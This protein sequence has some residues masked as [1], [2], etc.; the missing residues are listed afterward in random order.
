MNAEAITEL[1]LV[2]V[3]DTEPGIRRRRKGKGFSYVMPDG[4][5]LADELQRARIGALGL[6]PAYENV[7]ICLYENGHLQATGIDARGRKQY[8]YHKE[9]QS[10]RSA[11]KFH[12]LIEFGR[13]LPKIRRTV[14]RHLD[15][16]TEDVNGVL[17]ALTTLLDEAHLR[18][19]NQAY[20]RENGT[21]GATTLLK[22]H[23]KIVDGQIELKF[24]AKGGKR[25]QRSLK[26]PR[27]QKILEEIADLPGR[28]LFVWKD[29][30]AALKPIDS[31]RLNAYLAEISGIPISAKTFRT[32]AGSLAAFG[33]AREA[34]VCGSRPTVKQMSEASAEALHNTPAISRSSYI[35]PAII[36]LAGNDHPLIESSNAP[37]RGLRAEENRLLDF[38]TREIEE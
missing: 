33:A 2:Y 22:R 21:Y 13:A 35:H 17:A 32:W 15:T 16:G 38:L 5:T 20:V 12:Q 3:S 10:F 14:L 1:G 7:W 23:L 19:G 37:L 4:T 25:V 31:G 18:V 24:R 28:Q 26:H 9:W 36:A 11:G 30:N 34:I 29:E 6:P 27:L 8:R